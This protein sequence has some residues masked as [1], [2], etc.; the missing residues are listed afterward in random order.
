MLQDATGARIVDAI[1]PGGVDPATGVGWKTNPAGTAW[2]YR[3]PQGPSG[4][5]RVRVRSQ[6]IHART[7]Q[8]RGDRPARQLCDVACAHAREGDDDHRLAAG[9]HG[10]VRR[11]ALPRAT[12]D[13]ALRVQRLRKH[14]PV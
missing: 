7:A 3:N 11:G 2:R 9:D 12:A 10:P 6:G 13:A 4:I 1:I 5:V 8:V 14:A